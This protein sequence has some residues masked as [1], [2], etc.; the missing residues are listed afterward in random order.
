[1]GPNQQKE[2]ALIVLTNPDKIGGGI[3]LQGLF[4]YLR[5]RLRVLPSP[6]RLPSARFLEAGL[7]AGKRNTFLN[8]LLGE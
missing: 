6:E 3:R 1:M 7:R 4:V 8:D 5:T 2:K